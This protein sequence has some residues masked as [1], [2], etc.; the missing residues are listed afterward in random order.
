MS[1]YEARISK[2]LEWMEKERVDVS[3]ITSPANVMY[4]SGFYGDPHERFMGVIVPLQGSPFLLVPALD[5]DKA[6]SKTTLLVY[7]HADTDDAVEILA[8]CLESDPKALQRVAIEKNHMS[9]ARLEEMQQ[10][11]SGAVFAN[12]EDRLTSLRMKKDAQELSLMKKAAKAA[13]EAVAFAL[14]QMAPGKMEFELVQAIESFVKKMGADRMAFDTMVLAGEKSALPHGVPG[15]RKI[16][17]GD[18]VLVDLGIVWD[19]Y[20]SDITRTFAIGQA[21]ERQRQI[22]EAVLKANEAAIQQV[23]PG[24]AAAM[25]DRAARDVI[26]GAG[27]G[28]FFIHRVG[29][30]LGIEIHEP[31]SMHGNNQH[32]LIPGM[33]FTIEPG[34]YLPEVGGVRI[35]DDVFVTDSGCEVLTSY[36]KHLKIVPA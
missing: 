17:A 14:T 28:E 15:S 34:I 9:V 10:R 25:I 18:L 5:R 27:F 8:G 29:H 32:R 35:E 24:I 4:L 31:P 11:F 30:G 23:R 33:T 36:P 19:G 2:L 13:D 7:S 22:Y 20:C 16:E 26:N 12:A 21:N 3:I 6:E 1:F